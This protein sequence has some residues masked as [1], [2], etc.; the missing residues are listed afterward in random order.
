MAQ[1]LESLILESRRIW[2]NDAGATWTR[3]D[4]QFASQSGES[5][6]RRLVTQ[7]VLVY[8]LSLMPKARRKGPIM[9][10][11]ETTP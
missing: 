7:T 4:V 10:N 3:D 11:C 1:G 8:S 5:T 9:F 6:P 2:Q